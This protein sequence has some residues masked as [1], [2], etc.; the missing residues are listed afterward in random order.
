M[1]LTLYTDFSLRVLI[2]LSMHPDRLVTIREISDF[3]DIS[4]NH[5]VKVVHH[6]SRQGILDTVQGKRG[7]LRLAPEA[8]TLSVGAIV[9]TTEPHFQMAECFQNSDEVSCAVEP[10]CRLKGLLGEASDAFLQVLDGYT[11]ADLLIHAPT[12]IA[13]TRSA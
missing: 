1:Q 3:Y 9:R 7:G 11:V 5:L 13:D 12:A 6:L 2:Y 8:K 10:V 4:R